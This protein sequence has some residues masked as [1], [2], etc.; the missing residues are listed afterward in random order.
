MRYIKLS[1][2][3]KN[4]GL[5]KT[6]VD[7]DLLYKLSKFRWCI[8]NGGYAARRNGNKTMQMHRYII[9]APS[10]ME[11]DHINGNK[12]DNRR[13]NLRLVTRTQ[14]NANRGIAS[15]NTSG[16]KGVSWN[17]SLNLWMVYVK[18][19][20]KRIVKYAKTKEEAAIKYNQM[21]SALFGEY[22][23]LNVI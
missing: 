18:L 1:K 17:K 14:N 2:Q 15:N 16:Y 11:V 9:Q 4:K 20:R 8:S 22:A 21:A 13:C 7:P 19:N 5:Y 12:L 6:T 3:G 23:R 10:E